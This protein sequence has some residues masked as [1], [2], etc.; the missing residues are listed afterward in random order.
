MDVLVWLLTCIRLRLLCDTIHPV[1]I[2]EVPN[3]RLGLPLHSQKFRK[4]LLRDPLLLS[5]PSY[6]HAEIVLWIVVGS[7]IPISIAA[8]RMKMSLPT[9]PCEEVPISA[10]A[11]PMSIALF[12]MSWLPYP[13]LCRFVSCKCSRTQPK[14]VQFN[15]DVG[16]FLNEFRLPMGC[17]VYWQ[18]NW[19]SRLRQY[20]N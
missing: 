3:C 6:G 11:R 15:L 19:D 4:S 18:L 20:S 13:L 2:L 17:I 5:V 1:R 16:L 10:A 14:C 12:S 7:W 9:E 8:E